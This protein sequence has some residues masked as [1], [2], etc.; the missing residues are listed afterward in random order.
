M[1]EFFTSRNSFFS[2]DILLESLPDKLKMPQLT[3]YKEENDLVSH[4][5]KYTSWMEPKD[6][7]GAIMGRLFSLT[8]G[9]KGQRWL[10]MLSQRSI[11]IWN[12]L[13]IAFLAQFMVSQA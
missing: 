9:D 6:A 2:E 3:R 12:D 13:A 7:G 11:K 1:E 4:L 5:N 10:R 8:L